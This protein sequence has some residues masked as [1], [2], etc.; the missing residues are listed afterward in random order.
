MFKT[1]A[2]FYLFNVT[3]TQNALTMVPRLQAYK[4]ALT[5]TDLSII[6]AYCNCSHKHHETWPSQSQQTY[7][8]IH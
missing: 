3:Y 8:L 7:Q 6:S 1:A 5:G 2:H 4:V